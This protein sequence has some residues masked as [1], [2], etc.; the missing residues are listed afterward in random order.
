V[1]MAT[2]KNNLN[3]YDKLVQE[4]IM[5]ALQDAKVPDLILDSLVTDLAIQQFALCVVPQIITAER[6]LLSALEDMANAQQE[7]QSQQLLYHS[8]HWAL[9]LPNII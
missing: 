8:L 2:V 3:M 9:P 4:K 6:Q 7:L 1:E 5:Q